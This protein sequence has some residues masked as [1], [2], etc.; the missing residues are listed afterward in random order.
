M[1]KKNKKKEKKVPLIG[2]HRLL[3]QSLRI[4][5]LNLGI[6]L[7]LSLLSS[8]INILITLLL[9]PDLA[10]VYQGIWFAF[11]SCAMLWINRH[12]VHSNTDLQ[13]RDALY[14]GTAPLLKFF[15][16]S[17]MVMI[18][19]VPFSLGTFLFLNVSRLALGSV[20][21]IAI[22]G[23]ILLLLSAL[24]IFLISRSVFALI[25][26]TLPKIHPILS[27]KISWEL[28]KQRTGQI[29]AR[30]GV[31]IVYS[32]VLIGAVSVLLSLTYLQLTTALIVLGILINF[33]LTP[34]FYT[35][36]YQIYRELK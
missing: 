35:Y 2:A 17:F 16:T 19:T 7:R 5:R 27:M 12:I 15:L 21:A 30:L 22:A 32:A 4:I 34:I 9:K 20:V 11:Y 6:F 25:I 13:I 1:A 3:M 24:S 18:C 14:E 8:I 29:F 33:F 28:T 31:V 10:N 36:L 26:V 23:V